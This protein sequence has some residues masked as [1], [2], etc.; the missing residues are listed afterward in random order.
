MRRTLCALSAILF[1]GIGSLGAQ[2]PQPAPSPTPQSATPGDIDAIWAYAGT[3]KIDTEDLTTPYSK[4]GHKVTSLHN[5]CWR[6][7]PYVACRQI[8]DG[9]SKVLIVF[10]CTRPD[11]YCIS[12]Q[13]PSDGSNPSSGTMHIEGNTWTFPWQTADA[14][15][16]T[17]FRVVNVWPTP[18]TIDYR[19]E[20]S[21]DQVHWTLTSTGHEVKISPN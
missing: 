20:F 6:S 13:I 16:T 11:H 12:Y 18:T 2:S 14:G 3:W 19:Q 1:L 15:K 10:T 7:G 21:T 17:Y 5:E 8:V 4:A 9:E